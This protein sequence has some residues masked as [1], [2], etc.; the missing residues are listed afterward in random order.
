MNCPRCVRRTSTKELGAYRSAGPIESPVALVTEQHPA[1]VTVARCPSCAGAFASH[2]AMNAIDDHGR[3]AR[4]RTTSAEMARRAAAPGGRAISCPECNSETT[5][6]EWSFSTLVFVD[7]CIECR[8]VW[9]DGGELEALDGT[10]T[11]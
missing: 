4:A 2:D 9:L 8:G 7:I 1:R 10:S 11:R 5:R 6:R 3:S